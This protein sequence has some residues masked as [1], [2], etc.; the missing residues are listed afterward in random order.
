MK[1]PHNRR[2]TDLLTA[3]GVKPWLGQTSHERNDPVLK[4]LRDASARKKFLDEMDN[5]GLRDADTKQT[6]DTPTC[7]TS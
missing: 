3:R 7:E 6:D 2:T 5:I 4:K 1:Q